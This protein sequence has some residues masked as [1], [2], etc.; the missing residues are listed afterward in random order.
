MNLVRNSDVLKHGLFPTTKFNVYF[1][2]RNPVS[3]TPALSSSRDEC[4]FWGF[5]E[6]TKV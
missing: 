5:T 2:P 6:K 3:V 1:K 4:K